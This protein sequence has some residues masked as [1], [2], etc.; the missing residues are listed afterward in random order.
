[1]PLEP[2][3]KWFSLFYVW[4]H[5]ILPDPILMATPA[6]SFSPS[7]LQTPPPQAAFLTTLVY[8]NSPQ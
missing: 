3:K 7:P 4:V 6:S 2:P 8:L 1:M 5:N